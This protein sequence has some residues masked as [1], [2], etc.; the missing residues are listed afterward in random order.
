MSME[1]TNF[2]VVEGE[3]AHVC[4]IVTGNSDVQIVISVNTSPITAEG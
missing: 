4:A 2:A 3:A 1:N